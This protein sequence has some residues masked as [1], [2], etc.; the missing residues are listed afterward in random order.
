MERTPYWLIQNGVLIDLLALPV[1]VIFGYGVYLHWQ[2]IRKGETRLR[3]SLDDL[4]SFLSRD[5][6]LAVLWNGLLGIRVYRRPITGF[7]HGLVFWG[8]LLLFIGTILVL[9]NVMFGLGVMSG[10]FYQWFMAVTLDEFM[11][12][13]VARGAT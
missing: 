4:R 8:M 12:V 7:F 10:G 13:S 2:R 5:K 11:G 3:V 9:L 6:V 1:V